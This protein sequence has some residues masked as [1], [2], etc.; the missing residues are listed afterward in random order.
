[1]ALKRPDRVLFPESGFTKADAVDYYRRVAKWLLPHL[2]NVPVSFKRFPDTVRG[3]SFWEKDAPSFTPEWVKTFAVP[4]RS[5]ESSI[6]YLV[7]NDVRTLKWVA[8]A[9][10]IE[11]HPFLHRTTKPER[12]TSVVFD[13]DPGAGADLGDCCRVALLLREALLR[14][15]LESYAKVSGSKGL[16]VYVPLNGTLTHDV[17]LPFSRLVAEELARQHPKLVTAKMGKQFRARKVFIDWSQNADFKTT[18]AVYSLRAKSEQPFVSM[19]VT[20][21]EVEE[22]DVDALYFSPDD[23]LRRLAKLGDLFAPVLHKKQTLAGLEGVASAPAR[24]P[25]ADEEAAEVVVEGI[26]LPKRR[27][28]SGRRLFVVVKMDGKDELWLD[29]HGKFRRWILQPDRFG[30][31]NLI[32]TPAQEFP[33]DDAYYRG[34][35]PKEWRK[36]VSIED[37]GSYELIDGSYAR[38]R[39]DFWFTGRVLTGAWTLEKTTGEEHRSWVLR[40]LPAGTPRR[41]GA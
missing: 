19:P 39:F 16:Q 1:M 25:A 3:E 14:I 2:K 33:I 10:G 29:M 37:A 24:A 28:Q 8:E 17:T 40:P 4:R 38:K 15:E 26:R 32:A 31:K 36:R 20:W 35:V 5:G 41:K 22:A 6:R 23:A 11:L 12:A 34:V 13:L 7:V 9:G 21:E 30:T 18:V 27:S